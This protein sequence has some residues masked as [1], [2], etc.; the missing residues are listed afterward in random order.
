MYKVPLYFLRGTFDENAYGI[1]K[2]IDLFP[3]L[4]ANRPMRQI[5]FKIM[6]RIVA[7][8]NESET[9]DKPALNKLEVILAKTYG[10][11]VVSHFVLEPSEYSTSCCSFIKRLGK[12]S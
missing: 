2:K 1:K 8:N 9:G 3:D 6:K 4:A 10:A 5:I 11:M 12:G 7:I